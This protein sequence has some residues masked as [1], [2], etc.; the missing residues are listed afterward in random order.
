MSKQE[1][2]RNTPTSPGTQNSGLTR[3]MGCGVQIKMKNLFMTKKVPI[4]LLID[5]L[6]HIF[7]GKGC[8][9]TCFK[10]KYTSHHMETVAQLVR[11]PACYT[12][13]FMQKKFLYTIWGWGC[14]FKSCLFS[15]I[16]EVK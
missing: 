2:Q 13:R 16:L 9:Y 7:L 4:K 8:S 5:T 10:S 1:I 15:I 3:L 12:S 6:R 11:A 14:R